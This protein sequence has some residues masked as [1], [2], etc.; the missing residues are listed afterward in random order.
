M[1]PKNKAIELYDKIHSSDI[2][3]DK[4]NSKK[5]AFICIDEITNLINESSLDGGNT[6]KW[7]SKVKQE[8]DKL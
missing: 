1:T 3:M 6:L 8:I 7:W 2:L 5:C 4:V